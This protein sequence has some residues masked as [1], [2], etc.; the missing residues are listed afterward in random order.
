MMTVYLLN[1][2]HNLYSL[3]DNFN[4]KRLFFDF[5]YALYCKLEFYTACKKVKDTIHE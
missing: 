4:M 5:F 1:G 3:V 2:K